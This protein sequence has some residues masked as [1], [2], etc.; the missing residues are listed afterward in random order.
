MNGLLVDRSPPHYTASFDRYR[1]G[2]HELM[3]L[4]RVAVSRR[5]TIDLA[6][7]QKN[8]GILGLS[9]V[10]V[11]RSSASSRSEVRSSSLRSSSAMICWGSAGVLSGIAVICLAHLA[12]VP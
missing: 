5:R 2:L 6:T 1:I 9:A 3:I 12:L 7:R 11:C 10:V 8:E 4:E